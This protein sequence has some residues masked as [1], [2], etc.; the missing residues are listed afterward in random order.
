M[1]LL[2][3][4]PGGLAVCAWLACYASA[5][6]YDA[7]ASLQ[8]PVSYND[9]LNLSHPLATKSVPFEFSGQKGWTLRV[10][11]AETTHHGNETGGYQLEHPDYQ[12]PK[13]PRILTTAYEL[14]W[15]GDKSLDATVAAQYQNESNRDFCM[16][17]PDIVYPAKVTNAYKG[18]SSCVDAFGSNCVNAMIKHYNSQPL[19]NRGCPQVRFHGLHAC[20]GLIPDLSVP[21][22]RKFHHLMSRKR[23]PWKRLRLI[24]FS[25]ADLDS[26]SIQ[27]ISITPR[28]LLCPT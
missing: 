12:R 15:P 4:K 1:R 22:I 3:A 5:F 13:D 6:K 9:Q 2:N 14:E 28:I 18:G 19:V 17:A 26:T 20:K 23:M 7:F 27:N 10:R 11:I 24:L 8:A 16:V 25:N 21:A